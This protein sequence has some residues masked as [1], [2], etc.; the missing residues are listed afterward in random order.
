MYV[1]ARGAGDALPIHR[2]L[3]KV[4]ALHPVFVGRTVCEMCEGGL[5]Q[6]VTFQFPIVGQT[7]AG[8]VAYRPVI[9]FAFNLLREGLPLGMAGNTSVT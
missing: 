8:A 1:V 4:I 6:G 3:Y 2:A 7:K 9:R 5:A